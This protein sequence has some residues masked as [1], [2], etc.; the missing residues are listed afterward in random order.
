MSAAA[1]QEK[2]AASEGG[3]LFSART[4]AAI[5]GIGVLAFIGTIYLEV[6]TDGGDPSF[7]ISPTTY[8]SSALGHKA[9]LE[10]LRRLEVPVVVSRF[11]SGEK[12][13]RGSL[14]LLIEPEQSD[15]SEELVGGFGNV[16][17]GLLVLPKW[18]GG[19]DLRK[20]TWVGSMEPLPVAT[21]EPLLKRAQIGGKLQRQTGTF[22]LALPEFGGTIEITDPQTIVGS[23][24]KPIVTL[25][26]GILIG[27]A[28]LGSGRQW[29]LS[30][31]DLI[32]NH[33]IDEADNALVA[34]N[35]IDELRPP[36]GVVI[37]DETTHG[38]EQ[39]PNLM[40]AALRLPFVIVTLSVIVAVLLAVWA[41]ARRF[42]RPQPEGRALQ[43]GKVTLIRTAA[44]L[45]HQAGRRSGAVELVLS[46]YLKAQIADVLAR[47]NA[48]R[49]LSDARQINWLDDLAGARRAQSRLRP[50]AEAIDS[51]A[52]SGATDP[53]R[54]L[55]LA[56][57]LHAWKQEFL[58]GIGKSSSHR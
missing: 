39:R 36:G 41:G 11:Q 3:D 24:L 50:L 34:V 33:G 51:A 42:G 58:N 53:A 6:F 20:P 38:F 10:I 30:D 54:A 48:P 46:R 19:I 40:K 32:S 26:G 44:D 52:R 29:V 37:F 16:P 9:F 49:G 14:L 23:G 22:T 27:E 57:D 7:E 35:M 12:A 5:I 1:P 15:A 13:G 31:P 28:R 4:L 45:L 56:A 47:V 21:I 18:T 25:N 43:P 55:Q 17:H 2:G 8:S